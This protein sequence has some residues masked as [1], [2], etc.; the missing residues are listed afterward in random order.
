MGA[1]RRGFT[2]VEL[3][4]VIAIIGILIALLL[5]AVQAA[6][7]AARRSQCTNNLKQLGLG[8]HNYESAN[9]CFPPS[10]LDYGCGWGAEPPGKLFKNTHGLALMLPF[11]EQAALYQMANFS[12][13][14]SN[15][16][17]PWGSAAPGS[18]G[19]SAPL[20]GD[21]GIGG[22][23]CNAA[24][25]ATRVAVFLCPS[26]PGPETTSHDYF[27]STTAPSNLVPYT[28]N[29]DF[30]AT[31]NSFNYPLPNPPDHMF[32]VNQA[33]A[34]SGVQDGLSNTAAINEVTRAQWNAGS[35]KM[36]GLRWYY[37]L[38]ADLSANFAQAGDPDP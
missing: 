31:R 13:A 2:L 5:P 4:V 1:V 26:D 9:K 15:C 14:F 19:T 29:Y 12:Y 18:G 28:T 32:G 38:S 30:S 8:L 35:Q 20:A 24:V 36:W 37:D 7:E 34:I 25:A 22:A 21:C 23:T 10:G 33:L 16:P 11:V 3:L 6:R 27:N 17:G